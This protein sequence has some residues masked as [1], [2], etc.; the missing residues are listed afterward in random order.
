MQLLSEVP[1]YW[2]TAQSPQVWSESDVPSPCRPSPARAQV[3]VHASQAFRS[4]AAE[5]RPAG[6][7]TQLASVLVV[8]ARGSW[9]GSQLLMTVWAAQDVEPVLA[10]NCP[11]AQSTQTVVELESSSNWPAP[12]A[13]HVVPLGSA[14]VS[15]T[16]PAAQA[17]QLLS[18]A[19]A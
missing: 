13:V 9:L 10:V 19:A 16:D 8:P 6:Q 12:H 18:E 17:M 11:L 7:L 4:A 3:V 14:R 1:A 2:P 5:N 15:V